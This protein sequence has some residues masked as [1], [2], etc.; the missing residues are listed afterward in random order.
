MSD[1]TPGSPSPP[2]TPPSAPPPQSGGG[3][4]SNA[5][6][7]VA[8]IGLLLL[9][10]VAVFWGLPQLVDSGDE[11]EARQ[12]SAASEQLDP[13]PATVSQSDIERQKAK[14]DAEAALERALKRQ[15]ELEEAD[16]KIWAREDFEAATDRLAE[17]D[18]RFEQGDYRGAEQAYEAGLSAFEAIDESRPERLEQAMRKGREALEANRVEAA[19][20]RYR[21]ATALA[22]DNEEAAEGLERAQKREDVLAHMETGR[23]HLEKDNLA[24]ALEAFRA[25]GE[26]DPQ[27]APAREAARRTETALRERRFSQSMSEVFS[28]L[29]AGKFDAAEEALQRA[30]Q[31]KPDAA[32]IA[33]A[34]RRLESERRQARLS[35]L[36]ERAEEQVASENWAGAVETYSAALDVDSN[37]AFATQGL[38]RAQR[39]AELD[40]A[41]ERYLSDPTRL[42]SPAPRERAEA[43]L[44]ET[45]RIED[46]GPKLR[47]QRGEL[48]ELLEAA[49][50]PQTVTIVSD[51]Q[52]EVTLARIGRLG[53]FQ[54]RE[55]KLLPGDYAAVGTRDGY[56]D[57]RREFKVRP[58]EAPD[59]I[60]VICRETV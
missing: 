27:Y 36:R 25:A 32:E 51:G 45:A 11:S 4:G 29:D 23:G 19:V 2:L 20:E 42:Y 33:T 53:Q 14:R 58:G 10:A 59:E 56:R 40:A 57:V 1:R 48:A 3:G 31:I 12:D 52:T 46:P 43:L 35:A 49:R 13:A 41:F 39:R 34:E 30:R 9:L 24:Q 6:W 21:I 26:L 22:P 37:V 7:I 50:T 15:A 54:E 18:A 8:G 16:V 60:V 55:V 44:Q 17:G 38:P 28:A 47:R 5:R